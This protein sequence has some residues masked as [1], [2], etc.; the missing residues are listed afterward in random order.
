[1]KRIRLQ[2]AQID[3]MARI[4][5]PRKAMLSRYSWAQG[6][7][8]Q[9]AT[10]PTRQPVLHAGFDRAKGCLP[11]IGCGSA[12]TELLIGKTLAQARA[13]P[14][15]Q[16]VAAVGGLPPASEHASHLAMAVLSAALKNLGEGKRK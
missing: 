7:V 10:P 9:C 11:A 13:L 8:A 12:L 15:E 6:C 16:I 2:I 1:M 4:L 5:G 14:R 3:V